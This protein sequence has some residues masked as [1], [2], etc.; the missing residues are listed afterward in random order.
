MQQNDV[1]MCSFKPREHLSKNLT[2]HRDFC[3]PN[4]IRCKGDLFK[5]KPLVFSTIG[6]V[7][8]LALNLFPPPLLTLLFLFS[9]SSFR[10]FFFFCSN[11]LV[12]VYHRSSRS[13]KKK[14]LPLNSAR[15]FRLCSYLTTFFYS[16]LL[17][18]SFCRSFAL[19]LVLV[20][21]V[22]DIVS[23]DSLQCVQSCLALV[24]ARCTFVSQFGNNCCALIVILFQK[25]EPRATSEPSG[26][27]CLH[28]T[29]FVLLLVV[30][31]SRR[32]LN[33]GKGGRYHHVNLRLDRL[34]SWCLISGSLIN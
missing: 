31:C 33:P 1:G 14:K 16:L 11:R 12:F 7:L 21:R 28:R 9:F 5:R 22:Y 18:L 20:L 13:F 25:H 30:Y 4:Y 19:P 2:G 34:N 32:T 29:I 27:V 3:I 6:L 17:L 23:V 8:L 26:P 15:K 24:S 10:R